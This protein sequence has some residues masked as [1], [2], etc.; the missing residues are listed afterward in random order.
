MSHS[1]D[2][3]FRPRSVAIVGASTRKGT[4]GREIFDKLLSTDFNGPVYPVNPRAEYIH[5][6]KAYPNI[7]AIP[8]KVELAVIVVPKAHVPGIVKECTECGVKGLVVLTA[9]FKETG[10]EGARVEREMADMVKKSGMR[11]IGPNC[12]GVI[13]L[14]ESVRL[15][16][17]FAPNVPHA[18]TVALASQSGAL[19]QTIL[20]HAAELN[21]GIAMFASVGN[22]ADISGNDLLEYWG[23]EEGIDVILMYLES[24]GNPQ[25]FITLA[26]QVSK[27]KPVIVIKSG[28]TRAG[29]RAAVSHT[30]AMAG[31]DVAYDALFKQCGVIRADTINE[32][33]DFA[34]GFATVP[35]PRGP[36][37]AI[38]T[39]AGGPGIMAAD[40]CDNYG[41]EVAQLTNK[42]LDILRKGLEADAAVNN[43]VD[44]LAGA[45]PEQF[46]F[47]LRCVLADQNVDSVIV[48]FVAPIITNPT[49]VALKISQ[50]THAFDKPVLG[51]FMGVR[52]VAT[53][54]E[55]LHRLRVPAYP[56]P[57][58]AAKTLAAMVKY[59]SWRQSDRGET[60]V[61]KVDRER[62]SDIM[63]EAA[64]QGRE[65]LSHEEVETILASYGIP[66]IKSAYCSDQTEI[67]AASGDMHYP[68]VLKAVSPEIT[69][70]SDVG[71][72]RLNLT[73]EAELVA[74]CKE[75]ESSL[76]RH[77]VGSSGL[78][79]LL[80]EMVE[81]GREVVLG[82]IKVGHLGR[83]V[84]FGL[85]GIYVE[86]LGDVAFRLARLTETDAEEM[87]REISGYPL[88]QGVRG[89]ESV[90]IE[91]LK[92]MLLRLSQMACDFPQ[93][94]ELDINPFVAF[95]KPE[96]CVAVDARIRISLEE[97]GSK[98]QALAGGANAAARR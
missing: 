58:S 8:E 19:G 88:L 51:C 27:Q 81:N 29:A 74:A 60:R 47:A 73:D 77:G 32:M 46:Q 78:S 65:H 37:V 69:H 62:V 18:G 68:L 31:M 21:L 57:E 25:R 34:L 17:T 7:S 3:I 70:K 5:S 92:E 98:P 39:N 80:Q 28:R 86:V 55:E 10:P 15:D 66:L 72:V 83:L 84:M 71:A 87:I 90:A 76:E 26:E 50:A 2:A 97:S 91:T 75:I 33:F 63:R 24:F 20:E 89:E 42:T 79:Y 11:M 94:E 36:R 40:A 54:V 4:L 53:G 41:L 56:Y 1:L 23:R 44:L 45:T 6:V 61:F 12:M 52:G 48:I 38:V 14:E 82:L 30:G 64:G 85:G 43:P 35:L 95:P 9:G 16:A 93:I 96:A 22:K 67:I 49:E 59:Q 13:N